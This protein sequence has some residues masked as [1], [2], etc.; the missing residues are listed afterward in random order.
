MSSDGP[1]VDDRPITK[2]QSWRKTGRHRRGP[3]D[4][5]IRGA[6]K[7]I[8]R[9]ILEDLKASQRAVKLG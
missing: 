1:E 5:E 9:V 2:P 3:T 6:G 8:A 7:Q 4:K